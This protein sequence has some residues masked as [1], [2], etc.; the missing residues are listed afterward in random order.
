MN[1]KKAGFFISQIIIFLIFLECYLRLGGWLYVVYQDLQNRAFHPSGNAYNIVCFGESI[2]ANGGQNS[3]PHILEEVLN[4]RQNKIHFHVLNKGKPAMT[5]TELSS[6]LGNEIVSLKPNMV[7]LMLGSNDRLFYQILPNSKIS[8]FEFLVLDRIKVYRLIK[9][10][11][12]DIVMSVKRRFKTSAP[13]SGTDQQETPDQNPSMA[14]ERKRENIPEGGL[15]FMKYVKGEN[16]KGPTS[17]P[18]Y[19]EDIIHYHPLTIR[20]F[21][22]MVDVLLKA[23]IRVVIMQYPLLSIGSLEQQIH[24]GKDV[25]FVDNETL[26]KNAVHQKTRGYFFGDDWGHLTPPG[27]RLLAEHLAD[28]VLKNL[29]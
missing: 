10:L 22:D 15:G 1:Y 21:R 23:R 20:N 29:K 18:P 11:T 3:Y 17:M 19:Y 2:T 12:K 27:S 6:A 8:A 28:E 14:E 25:L 4:F 24:G 16:W 5:T 9:S 26:F 13:A 7:V